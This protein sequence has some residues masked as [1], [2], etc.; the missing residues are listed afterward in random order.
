MKK[1][2]IT[3]SIAILASACNFLKVE[4]IGKSDIEG[5]FSEPDALAP[6]LYGIYSGAYSVFDHYLI[7]YPE[8][9]ADEVLLSPSCKEWIQYY[10]HTLNSSDEA[11]ALGF[12][13]KN[14]YNVISNCNQVIRYAPEL[15]KAHPEVADMIHDYLAQAYFMRALM[16]FELVLVYAQNYSFTPDASH[17]GIA[18]V[19]HIPSLTEKIGRSSV[20]E[21]YS[22]VIKDILCALETFPTSSKYDNIYL[23]TPLSC[24]ALLSR[25]YLYMG[26]YQKAK[27]YSSEVISSVPLVSRDNYI[28]MFCSRE[29]SEDESIFRLN[30]NQKSQSSYSFYK[31]DDPSA[32]PSNRVKSLYTDIR[33]IRKKLLSYNED[34][35]NI[36]IKYTCT[37]NVKTEEERYYNPI[38]FR[39]SEMYLI[40][41]EAN[42][43]MN[44]SELAIDD[45]KS[46]EARALGIDRQSVSLIG[47]TAEQAMTLIEKERIKELCFE[48]HRFYDLA[49]WHEN[50]ERSS[51]ASSTLLKLNY[52]D[53]RWVL[54]IPAV[55]L[56]ANDAMEG[57]PE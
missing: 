28:K 23:A 13:W 19:Q 1:T 45:I 26:D 29:P 2:F 55:E 30:G 22:V 4:D 5:Y 18:L 15:A 44:N 51:D 52:P 9:A 34:Y 53:P 41:A 11:G 17:P 8:V 40:R 49:R 10:E 50:M 7:T 54:P 46:L 33:D 31:Y 14:C 21:V 24:K 43:K 32:R 39:V 42:C 6:A 12:I 27:E 37:D 36:V 47:S 35:P 38:I 20:K 56:E 3:I 57:N 48:G 16:H 25:I